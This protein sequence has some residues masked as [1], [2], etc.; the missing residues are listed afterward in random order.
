VEL[1]HGITGFRDADDPPLPLCD[2]ADFRGHCYAAARTLNG[3]VVAVEAPSR[4]VETNFAR[5]VLELPTGRVAVLLN[6]HFPLIAFAEPPAEGEGFVRFTDSPGLAEAFGNFGIYE[7]VGA[8][9]LAA[10]LTPEQRRRLAP[11]EREQ[12]EYWQPRRVGDVVFNFWD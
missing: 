11:A 10:P 5:G 3:R 8:S 6:A 2:V 9:E 1:P 4:G 12:I 7:V